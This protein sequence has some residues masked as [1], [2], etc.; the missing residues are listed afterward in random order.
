MV[1][2]HP[3]RSALQIKAMLMNGAET[4]V[5]TNPAVYPGRLITRIGAGELRVDRSAADLA[6]DGGEVRAR[7]APSRPASS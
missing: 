7:S 5:Y 1:Q 6:W 4:N 3:A 2:A